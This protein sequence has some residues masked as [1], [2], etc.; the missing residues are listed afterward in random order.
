M[1]AVIAA[2]VAGFLAGGVALFREHR[3]EERKLLV[4]ARV[5]DEAFFKVE[6][7]VVVSLESNGWEPFNLLPTQE[8]FMDGWEAFREDLAGHLTS[9]EWKDLTTTLALHQTVS[10]MT[11]SESPKNAEE[12]LNSLLTRLKSSRTRLA[13]YCSARFSVWRQLQRSRRLGDWSERRVCG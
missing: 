7:A 1:A 6:G 13:P 4:A 5:I 8:S 3:I 10:S 11:Q 9:S 2:I 12:L